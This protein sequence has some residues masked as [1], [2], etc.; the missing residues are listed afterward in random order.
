M[1]VIFQAILVKGL[2][3]G[4]LNIWDLQLPEILKLTEAM[5]YQGTGALE[6]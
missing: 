5:S 1:S 3:L 6:V 2:Y 4:S